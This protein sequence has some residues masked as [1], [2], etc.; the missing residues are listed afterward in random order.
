MIS[1]VYDV[2][3]APTPRPLATPKPAAP[4]PGDKK[5]AGALLKKARVI[6]HAPTFTFDAQ[7]DDD[8]GVMI[9]RV[10]LKARMTKLIESAYAEL[11]LP[12]ETPNAWLLRM[13]YNGVQQSRRSKPAAKAPDVAA[14]GGTP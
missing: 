11:A 3:A 6:R 9:L 1:R 8:Q 12:D 7:T 5:P 10:A 2:K 13:L 4:K 14:G